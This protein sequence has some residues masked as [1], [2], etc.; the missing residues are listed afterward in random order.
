MKEDCQGADHCWKPG[1]MYMGFCYIF[2]YRICLNFS[3]VRN[4]KDLG[5]RGE[6]LPKEETNKKTS[7]SP[8]FPAVFKKMR[9][10]SGLIP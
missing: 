2:Y 8:N 4:L 3:I 10:P 6:T 9:A 1:D 5:V 7:W